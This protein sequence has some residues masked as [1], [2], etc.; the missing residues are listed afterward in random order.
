MSGF[1]GSNRKNPRIV[2]RRAEHRQEIRFGVIPRSPLSRLTT[3]ELK[4]EADTP[5]LLLSIH[6]STIIDAAGFG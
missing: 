3:R 1:A 6:E 5:D 2:A 4:A